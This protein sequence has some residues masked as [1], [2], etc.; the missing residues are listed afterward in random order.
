MTSQFTLRLK[1]N[2]KIQKK[3]VSAQDSADLWSW[4]EV[5]TSRTKQLLKTT[6]ICTLRM[7]VGKTKCDQIWNNDMRWQYKKRG[8]GETYQKMN[9]RR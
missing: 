3:V 1:G 5:D 8:F 6:E 7:I 2:V 9:K 4:H